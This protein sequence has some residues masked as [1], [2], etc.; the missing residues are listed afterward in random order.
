M[1][2]FWLVL[3]VLGLTAC[4][5]AEEAHDTIKDGAINTVKA[6]DRARAVGDLTIAFG[7]IQTYYTQNNKYPAT[8]EELKLNLYNPADLVYDPKTGKVHSKSFP[9]L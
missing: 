3:L 7:A 6:P 4:K 9:N 5:A 8:L 1:K 2:R